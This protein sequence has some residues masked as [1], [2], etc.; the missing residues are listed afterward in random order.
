MSDHD[1]N[2]DLP[3]PATEQELAEAEAFAGKVDDLIAGKGLPSVG[4]VEERELLQVSSMIRAGHHEVPL[5]AARQSALIEA[6]MAHALPGAKQAGE[7]AE[8]S[9][10]DAAR[11]RKRRAW[12]AGVV[13]MVAVAAIALLWFRSQPPK[14]D[15]P[16]SVAVQT[17]LPEN[18]Q[19][20]AADALI[21]QIAPEQSG[22]AS[23]RLDRI[24]RDRMAGYRALQYRRLAG[25]Q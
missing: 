21:G 22:M 12:S 6:A 16:E 13:S 3:T 14:G 20:R 19:S 10:L 18:Q 2:E 24:Y 15:V 11:A 25:P 17:P 7:F 4:D 5:D 8:V 23:E 9:S 1:E